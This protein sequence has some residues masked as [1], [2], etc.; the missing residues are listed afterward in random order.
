MSNMNEG[1]IKNAP[2]FKSMLVPL[3]SPISLRHG[4][5]A[6]IVPPTLYPVQNRRDNDPFLKNVFPSG[7]YAAN[8]RTDHKKTKKYRL[9]QNKSK[10]LYSG[11]SKST[12]FGSAPD[13]LSSFTAWTRGDPSLDDDISL[14][15]GDD[16]ADVAGTYFKEISNRRDGMGFSPEVPLEIRR[17][18]AE[19]LSPTRSLPELKRHQALTERMRNEKVLLSPAILPAMDAIRANTK[20]GIKK[21]KPHTVSTRSS[22]DTMMTTTTTPMRSAPTAAAIAS[23]IVPKRLATTIDMEIFKLKDLFEGTSNEDAKKKTKTSSLLMTGRRFSLPSNTT[24]Q[25]ILQFI[26]EQDIEQQQE[27]EGEEQKQPRKTPQI[28]QCNAVNLSYFNTKVNAWRPISKKS[29][30]MT[31]RI[32]ALESGTGSGSGSGAG[33][34]SQQMLRLIYSLGSDLRMTVNKNTLGQCTA[35]AAAN[36]SAT[37][38]LRITT[39]SIRS[40]P[41][42]DISQ[43]QRL[44]RGASTR[45][46]A[47]GRV[48]RHLDDESQEMRLAPPVALA[49][50]Y[51]PSRIRNSKSTQVMK[52]KQAELASN[53]EQRLLLSRR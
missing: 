39:D 41:P 10:T 27:E 29:D 38:T 40:P 51:N 47:S 43:G 46:I 5:M 23:L 16:Y 49:R 45:S 7:F 19:P 24:L 31:A 13:L 52:E 18:T 11:G 12:G 30:W 25:M 28:M 35:S 15:G 6:D 2:T 17:W 4:T 14:G 1:E 36:A 44:S 26:C 37:S 21:C 20:H 8:N 48:S 34:P 3:N 53:L 33:Q 42:P 9:S 22:S 50:P 32:M